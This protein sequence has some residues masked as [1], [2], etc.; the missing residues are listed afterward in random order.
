MK[1]PSIG[2][3]GM[4]SLKTL[5]TIAIISSL[6]FASLFVFVDWARG[7]SEPGTSRCAVNPE[8]PL[9]G[10]LA[11]VT[12]LSVVI[13][14]GDGSEVDRGEY[15]IDT[16]G[17]DGT[18][19]SMVSTPSGGGIFALGPTDLNTTVLSIGWHTVY[20][21]AHAVDRFSQE[22]WESGYCEFMFEI[23][24]PS[25]SDTEGPITEVLLGQSGPNPTFGVTEIVFNVTVND[26]STGGSLIADAEF[27]VDPN[28]DGTPNPPPY[29]NGT[30][31]RFDNVTPPF[32]VSTQ[33][34][35][36]ATIDVS[37]WLPGEYTFYAHGKDNWNSTHNW[38]P[39]DTW[40][41]TVTGNGTVELVIP[42]GGQLW[43][44]GSTEII[45]WY[46]NTTVPRNRLRTDLYYDT[47]S[48]TGG[49][50]FLI[51]ENMTVN[52][53][54]ETYDWLVPTI[55]SC[56]VRVKV[57]LKESLGG[58]VFNILGE[59]TSY[60][61]FCIDSTAPYI[62]WT[63]PFDGEMDVPVGQQIVV[64]FSESMDTSSLQFTIGP[65]DPGGWVVEWNSP[66]D[67]VATLS[68]N[69]FDP[70]ITYTFEVVDARDKVGFG[71]ASSS[72]PNPFSFTTG[73]SPVNPP[74]YPPRNLWVERAPPDIILH[75]DS[76]PNA[77]YYNV[78]M[79]A[80]RLAP[81]SSWTPVLGVAGTSWTHVGAYGDGETWFYL[82]RGANSAGEGPNSTMGVKLD[83]QFDDLSSPRRNIYWIS[84]PY[85]T[86][87]KKA[88]DIA[89]ELGPTKIDVVGKWDPSTQSTI[90]YYYLGNRWRG[91][92]FD[93]NPGDGLFVNSVSDSWNWI[94]NGTDSSVTLRFNYNVGG[95][96]T[97]WISLPCTN[98]YEKA[99]DIVLDIE[100]S[101]TS[102]PTKI[103]EIG[104]WDPL[105][106]DVVTFRWTGSSWEGTDFNIYP[107][108]G[109]YF[110]ILSTFSW[111]PLLI[112]PEQT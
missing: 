109:V 48:G 105:T 4:R 30:G 59:D 101:L 64:G 51:D 31:Q 18:G 92:D 61:D 95:E 111:T 93:I 104:L 106:Q 5:G 37:S 23:R 10:E 55:D 88:S 83:K 35:A 46:W 103:D 17:P 43:G 20:V 49:Y 110:N 67:T 6:I 41:L 76:V 71:L 36:T 24:D 68:H 25:G 102:T 29:V 21:H 75:W 97:N 33:V 72:V 40:I 11:N 108:D 77:T 81:F 60:A 90:V 80:D 15:F 50:P 74:Q 16:V 98:A 1:V 89:S 9:Q 94:I 112:T 69:P 86:I 3:Q 91:T 73:S 56:T 54:P 99:S 27:F 53:N 100:G 52:D 47:M 8:S 96:N 107:G 44:G 14:L 62:S 39:F 78:Y 84:L 38:G 66:D 13:D 19:V 32:D 58:G 42:N 87:Y 2:K 70:Y 28:P 45:K 22:I 26:T 63:S 7:V 12:A 82:V 85:N 79:S 34:L 65:T 57:I